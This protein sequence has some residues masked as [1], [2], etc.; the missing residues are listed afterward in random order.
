MLSALQTIPGTQTPQSG[1]KTP[2][3]PH[4]LPLVSLRLDILLKHPSLCLI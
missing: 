1:L 4:F 2:A 3:A